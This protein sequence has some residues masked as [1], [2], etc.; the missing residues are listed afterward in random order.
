MIRTHLAVALLA[1]ASLCSAQIFTANLTGAV[2]DPTGGAIQS[3]TVK[4]TNVATK[5]VRQA[6][7][8]AEGRYTFSQLLPGR[9][10]LRAESPGFKAFVQT[11]ITLQASQSVA[12]DFPLQVGEVSQRVEVAAAVVQLDT[13][14]ANQS[15][16]LN[17]D[18]VAAL[19][20][21]VRNPF[22]LV[23][24]TAGVTAPATGISQS[25]ADQNHDRFG[26]NGGRSTT[27]GIL[28]DGVSV[29]TGN[30]WN[31][32]IYSPS[33]DS[34]QEVQIIR[35][36]YDSQYGRSGG[37]VVSVVTKGGGA[38]YHGT[39][40]D[41]LRNSVL[42]ANSWINNRGGNPRPMFQ[43][44]QYGGN[45]S[46]P[47]WKSRRLFFFAGYEA[48]RQGAPANS[49][50]TLPTTRERAGDFSETRNPNNT[51]SLIYN[52]FS[53]RPNP[54]GAGI[55]RDTF[56]GN[57]IPASMFDPVGV[58]A[59]A[60][61]PEANRTGNAIT[62][63]L[64]YSATGKS[65]NASDRADI[66]IDWARSEKHTMY[67]RFSDAWRIEGIPA[68]IWQSLTTTGPISGNPRYQMTIGNTFVPNPTWVINVLAGHGR[69]NERQRAR[70]YGRTGTE[71]GLPGSLISQIDIPN[72]PQFYMTN[73]S[74]IGHS[75]DL[76]NFSRTDN[77]QVNVTKERGVHSIRFG[78]AWES[79]KTT[80]GGLFSP[81][82]TFNRDMTS[83]PIAQLG[84]TTSGNAVASLLL[85][86]GASGNVQ[87]P[88]LGASNRLYYAG[89][90]QDTWRIGSRLTINPGLRYDIQRGP[91]ERFNRYSNFHYQ[92]ESPLGAR[93]GLPLR[94]GLVFLDSNQRAS[95][96]TDWLNFAPR[97]GISYKL[98]N[99]MVVRTGYGIFFPQVLGNGDMTGFSSTTPWVPSIGGDGINPQDLLRNPFPGGL[100][101]AVGS[102]DG[103]L[104]NIGRGAGSF[105]R[106]HPDPYMQNYSFDIQYEVSRSTVIEIG[107]AGHQG[108]KLSYGVGLNDNQLDPVLL[109]LGN[110]L[111]Q[112]VPN[113]F[114]GFIQG[115]A[116]SGRTVPRQRLL[117][118]FP[119]F[120]S[121]NRSNQVGGGSSS[122]NALLAKVTKQFSSG[123]ML[124][125]SYQWSKAIDNIGETEPSPGGAADGYR[126]NRDV[127]IERSLSA[128]NLPH[129]F[130]TAVVY[131]LPVG[132]GKALGANMNKVLNAVAGGWQTAGIIRFSSGLPVRLT[133]PSQI[134]QFGFG[135]QLPDIRDGREVAVDKRHPDRWFNTNAFAAPAPFTVGNSPRRLPLLTAAQQKNADVSIMKNF[136]YGERIRAQFRAEVFNLTNTPQFGWPDTMLGST[137][138]GV[139]SST[140]NIGP[141]NVQAGLKIDF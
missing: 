11:G 49:T 51:L 4:I 107:Y 117:R 62:N 81:E 42:D 1:G 74:N 112:Q 136:R 126:N 114:F 140:M 122:Y 61:Y 138:F 98:T 76:N 105:Q 134:S 6:V 113:P 14:T 135:V 108:R 63:A 15:V 10:E 66:R 111:T 13:Q 17:R 45:L 32:L 7:T 90:F 71:L 36:S 115:G 18:M 31:G 109:S 93:V 83:G 22:A 110:A 95:W 77:F 128:H 103:L 52:P 55:V 27:T 60:L 96:D 58:K 28:L 65:V 46:G 29:T 57:R 64:N 70:E 48:L 25:V 54:N 67:G 23:H 78:F 85:G 79:N 84:A 8:G 35:N 41:F 73:Y 34:V 33:V 26:F 123:L 50:V 91:T 82:F 104:T 133:A 102:A 59:V 9:Y 72:L 124:M 129:S 39:V 97:L 132:R 131:D 38:V 37:G 20:T 75:R 24:A 94:G 53:N 99:R 137:T 88:A 3:V 92:A 125:S 101:P 16:T 2:T 47:I 100:L 121:V 89:Y 44:N 21:N 106:H 120:D 12:L 43:R 86:T 19:P 118:P 5:E 127:G 116:L 130:V 139:V 68:N 56:P 80:G 69:W 87:K 40:F 119:H 141:R 30:G